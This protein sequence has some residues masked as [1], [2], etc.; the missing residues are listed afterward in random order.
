MCPTGHEYFTT[1]G[2]LPIQILKLIGGIKNI[3][4]L[5][6]NNRYS[7]TCY[8]FVLYIYY[9]HRFGGNLFF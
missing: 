5:R 4:V 6:N 8:I 3:R 2:K 9:Y 1:Q 7:R